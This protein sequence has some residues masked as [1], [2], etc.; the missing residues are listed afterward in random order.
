MYQIGIVYDHIVP[1]KLR[2]IIMA[3]LIMM[4]VIYFL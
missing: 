3:A 4:Y 2:W 1:D